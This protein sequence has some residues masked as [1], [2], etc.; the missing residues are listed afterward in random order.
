MQIVNKKYVKSFARIFLFVYII[1]LSVSIF[2]YHNFSFK[3]GSS[4][5]KSAGS[6]PYTDLT[7]DY[8]SV[9]ALHQFLQ[10]IDNFH[11]SSLKNVQS[12]SVLDSTLP[13]IKVRIFHS[14]DFSLQSPRAPPLFIS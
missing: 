12:L 14:E 1:F 11:Y 13:Q 5:S 6:Y 2:H 7:T 10:T 3:N 8:F 4:Y 9:C